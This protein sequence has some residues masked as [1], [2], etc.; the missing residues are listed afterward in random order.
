MV[1]LTQIGPGS[2]KEDVCL[3]KPRPNPDKAKKI[4]VLH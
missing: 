1:N 2:V 4:A 3:A